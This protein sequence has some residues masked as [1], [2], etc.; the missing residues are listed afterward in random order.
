MGGWN[1]AICV[2]SRSMII[3]GRY[4]WRAQE[5]AGKWSQGDSTALDQT[6]GKLMEEAGY[7]TYMTGKWHVNAPADYVFQHV[8]HVRPGMPGD[9][10]GNG[11]R[12]RK[13]AEAIRNR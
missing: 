1:G 11:G 8:K 2:A 3:S 5:M 10:W 6:W 7:D 4:L 12:G 13:V 9:A